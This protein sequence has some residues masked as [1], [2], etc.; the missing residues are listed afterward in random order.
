MRIV[1]AQ[2]Q[3][4]S[5][6]NSPAEPRPLYSAAPGRGPGALPIS[7][8]FS[9]AGIPAKPIRLQNFEMSLVPPTLRAI[10]L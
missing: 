2:V 3:R 10:A 1:H 6:Y 5:S 9:V 7:H 4:G 8:L